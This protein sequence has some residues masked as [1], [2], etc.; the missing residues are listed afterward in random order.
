MSVDFN[1]LIVGTLSIHTIVLAALAFS[2]KRAKDDRTRIL[3]KLLVL[4]AVIFPVAF[5]VSYYLQPPNSWLTATADLVYSVVVAYVLGLEIPGFVLLTRF[6]DGVV[7]ALED[8]RKELVTLGYSF[9]H[10]KQFK[11]TVKKIN[12]RLASAGIDGLVDDFVLACDRMSNLDR[13]FWSLLLSEVTISSRTFA[14][15]S[16]H[17]FPKLI[18]VMSLAGLSFL[19]AQLLKLFG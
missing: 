17:P 13:R 9:D 3:W 14:E 6:D 12:E 2:V 15:Q 16:K 8:L 7:G 11:E 4:E 10:L 1:Y 18:D 5:A 19:L